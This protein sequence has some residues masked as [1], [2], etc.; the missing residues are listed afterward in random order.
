[1]GIDLREHKCYVIVCDVCKNTHEGDGA[2]PHFYSIAEAQ[3]YMEMFD[4]EYQAYKGVMWCWGC[5]P[6]CLCGHMFGEHE[7]GDEPCEECE[8]DGFQFSNTN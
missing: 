5:S 7:F 3:E 2:I 4:C 8:C 6:T 1:M